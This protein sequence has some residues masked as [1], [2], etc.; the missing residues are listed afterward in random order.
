MPST[1]I[2]QTVKDDKDGIQL[3]TP[4]GITG[5]S[6]PGLKP[7][8]ESVE[9]VKSKPAPSAPVDQTV[10]DDK[11][12]IQ[13][14]KPNGITSVS[15]PESKPKVEF[16]GSVNS[17]TAPS[18]TIDQTVKKGK[19]NTQLAKPT[20]TSRISP[21]V[22]APKISTSA[23]APTAAGKVPSKKGKRE[24]PP[25]PFLTALPPLNPFAPPPVTAS[26]V[27]GFDPKA[28]EEA[29]ASGK[30]DF[31]AG[32]M[33]K[34]FPVKKETEREKRRTPTAP[35]ATPSLLPFVPSSDPSSNTNHPPVSSTFLWQVPKADPPR[36]NDGPKAPT[37]RE[38]VTMGE[39]KAEVLQ[40]PSGP[41]SLGSSVWGPFSGAGPMPV[42][43]NSYQPP[44]PDSVPSFPPKEHLASS[45]DRMEESGQD[46]QNE[47]AQREALLQARKE[48]DAQ[49]L[50]Q[51]EAQAQ[52]LAQVQPQQLAEEQLRL[53]AQ[54]QT[55][56]INNPP[57]NLSQIWQGLQTK[58][59]PQGPAGASVT[60]HYPQRP[61]PGSNDVD[62][63]DV[64]GVQI[65][66][67]GPLEALQDEPGTSDTVNGTIDPDSK[68]S[69][70]QSSF[71][72]LQARPEEPLKA[73]LIN[74]VPEPA[75][76]NHALSTFRHRIT[77]IVKHYNDTYRDF[78]D[79]EGLA[80]NLDDIIMQFVDSWLKAI[81]LEANGQDEPFRVIEHRG[82]QV[83][84]HLSTATKS[85]WAV[86]VFE[87]TSSGG[88]VILPA[89]DTP[90]MTQGGGVNTGSDPGVATGIGPV[91]GQRGFVATDDEVKM[92]GEGME[93]NGIHYSNWVLQGNDALFQ[94]VSNRYYDELERLVLSKN[95]QHRELVDRQ[96][97]PLNL[98]MMGSSFMLKL[99]DDIAHRAVK[100]NELPSI[101]ADANAI[102]RRIERMGATEW[103]ATLQ[104]FVDR[105]G[106]RK[107]PDMPDSVQA[108]KQAEVPQTPKTSSKNTSTPKA[109]PPPTGTLF[110]HEA[111]PVYRSHAHKKSGNALKKIAKEKN[112]LFR[113]PGLG[114]TGA[115]NLDG[116]EDSFVDFLCDTIAMQAKG[117]NVFEN[118]FEEVEARGY[119]MVRELKDS[120]AE[121]WAAWVQRYHDRLLVAPASSGLRPVQIQGSFA[122]NET[123]ENMRAVYF[124][125]LLAL[126]K[127]KNEQYQGQVDSFG[128]PRSIHAKEFNRM[129]K[130]ILDRITTRVQQNGSAD[131]KSNADNVIQE[132]EED[133]GGHSWEGLLRGLRAPQNQRPSIISPA[134]PTALATPSTPLS[135]S[136]NPYPTH[137][138]NWQ[139]EAS[140]THQA[141][142]IAQKYK[143]YVD[144]SASGDDAL[145]DFCKVVEG[146]AF[147]RANGSYDGYKFEVKKALNSAAEK[148]RNMWQKERIKQTD[149][150]W[151]KVD[152]GLRATVVN[153]NV[154]HGHRTNQEGRSFMLDDDQANLFVKWAIWQINHEVTK[155]GGV[156]TVPRLSRAGQNLI[157]K[158]RTG[159]YNW[160]DTLANFWAQTGEA[161][162]TGFKTQSLTAAPPT[163]VAPGP[164]TSHPY[165]PTLP[166]AFAPTPVPGVLVAP[167]TAFTPAP[168]AGVSVAPPPTVV[169]VSFPANNIQLTQQQ[170]DP[171]PAPN[172]QTKMPPPPIRASDPN[173]PHLHDWTMPM[174]RKFQGRTI[175]K[176]FKNHLDQSEWNEIELE[177]L[178]E[179]I[180]RLAFTCAKDD[181]A[182]YARKMYLVKCAPA[183]RI[184]TIWAKHCE[185]TAGT[186]A[187]ELA[188]EEYCP[189]FEADLRTLIGVMN[190]RHG[191]KTNRE[192]FSLRLDETDAAAFH[193]WTIQQ[194]NEQLKREGGSFS[195]ADYQRLGEQVVRELWEERR[196]W[197][198]VLEEFWTS[199]GPNG[200]GMQ[201]DIT[202]SA[203]PIPTAVQQPQ[204]QQNPNP[205]PLATKAGEQLRQDSTTSP[206]PMHF[207][208]D[209]ERDDQRK[210]LRE[211]LE[212]VA[213]ERLESA[214][215]LALHLEIKMY[216]DSGRDIV[217]YRRLIKY[218]NVTERNFDKWHEEFMNSDSDDTMAG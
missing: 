128:R 123:E 165:T 108:E 87:Y 96:G 63:A 70:M 106:A 25:P 13:S 18:P 121:Q 116:M 103:Q 88:E 28:H 12:G 187:A 216:E 145:V 177:K 130:L 178:A 83:L 126:V 107:L 45:G 212:K 172:D 182:I 175:Q 62:M 19:N 191:Y 162:E 26:R 99:L 155:I 48:A 138:G 184:R 153:M 59:L 161:S 179:A 120:S 86:M 65:Q 5:V 75:Y 169:P 173:P 46:Y 34:F 2:D 198:S 170:Q 73:L 217:K 163:A 27:G 110:K 97:R 77:Q 209:K 91:G 15:Q 56:S 125:R 197:G 174:R 60:G 203:F 69:P 134:T 79:S 142:A 133:E 55:Q 95:D 135:N 72:S 185:N 33:G 158:L 30:I 71:A 144:T 127:S 9:S 51:Q 196:D 146:Q 7:K 10:K 183:E 201:I 38:D 168:P 141:N 24:P 164:T 61:Q 117:K 210:I 81:A 29:L 105:T 14:T 119:Q 202:S 58:Q 3:A 39:A 21:L 92:H 188:I 200:S 53:Q 208:P 16:V 85:E 214:G 17:K 129:A 190:G 40:Q 199:A 151:K 94:H 93:R 76:M 1:P 180:E 154:Q 195:V 189:Q 132:Y 118:Q 66:A 122:K 74:K 205:T 156:V 68:L 47:V 54:N 140:R 137:S 32:G 101:K 23:T 192:G 98:D 67:V 152:E 111:K 114:E 90:I 157:K 124:P 176:A 35:V 159:E 139:T 150:D 166:S 49:L 181:F 52:L 82:A 31:G 136:N 102:C 207:N 44:G 22:A 64:D 36:S 149:R 213:G 115:L 148:V 204:V 143:G 167:P 100:G 4:T 186:A 171:T 43:I 37:G 89:L 104:D 50:A 211:K 84:H 218:E 193:K 6:Q 147:K 112:K 78:K 80:V 42:H 215:P 160:A 11:D 20:D 109:R 131:Y 194:I 206:P 8:V 41:P 57:L 113:V